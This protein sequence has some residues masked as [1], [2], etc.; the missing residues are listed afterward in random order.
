MW[1]SRS[2]VL[3]DM[4]G[5]A[6]GPREWDLVLTAMYFERFGWH[7]DDEYLEFASGYGFD[8]MSWP[9]YTVLRNI[10]EL[11]LLTWLALIP[12]NMPEIQAEVSGRVADLRGGN[13]D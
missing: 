8:V 3:V 4:D 11:I 1:D 2:R 9:G 6:A 12:W 10:R 13:A 7:S 5:F